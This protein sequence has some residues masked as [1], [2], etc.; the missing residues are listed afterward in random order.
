MRRPL[1]QLVVVAGNPRQTEFQDAL[2]VSCDE[3]DVVYVESIAGAYSR[4]KGVTP[5][6]IRIHIDIDDVAACRLLSLLTIDER[7]SRIPVETLA[8]DGQICGSDGEFA[9]PIP[10]WAGRTP[11]VVMN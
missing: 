2:L 8:M 7:L 3:C 10:E 4:I 6:L 1:R 9:G 11:M 5:D